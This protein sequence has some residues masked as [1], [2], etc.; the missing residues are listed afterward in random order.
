MPFKSDRPSN[1][2]FRSV[3]SHTS[4]TRRL[5]LRKTP[6][7]HKRLVKQIRVIRI[8]KAAISVVDGRI[9]PVAVSGETDVGNRL[10]RNHM[11]LSVCNPFWFWRLHRCRRFFRILWRFRDRRTPWTLRILLLLWRS[12]GRRGIV[13][14]TEF[15]QS[16]FCGSQNAVPPLNR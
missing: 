9:E 10:S 3:S 13:L 16:A 2:N 11:R 4:H 1:A 15:A 8:R 12:L 7:R 6:P 5:T 14:Q